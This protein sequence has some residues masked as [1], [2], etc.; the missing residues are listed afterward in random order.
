MN[1]LRLVFREILHRKLSFLLGVL[2]AAVAVA[3]LVA[4]LAMLKKH[5]ARTDQIIAAKEAET[6]REMAKL[7]DDYRK[8]MLKMGFNVLILPKDQNLSD[9]Y[10]DD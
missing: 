1:L 6:R 7:E 3:C 4:E 5:D 9:L 2:S 10:A 8:L